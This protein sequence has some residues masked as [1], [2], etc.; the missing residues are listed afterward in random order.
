[1]GVDPGLA[2]VGWGVVDLDGARLVYRA[3]GCVGTK[4]TSPAADRLAAIRDALLEVMSAWAPAEA[5]ME[6][7]FFSRNVTS[8]LG[9]A[10][11][12]GVIRL[13]F[14][15]RSVPL[16]EYLPKAI[17]QSVAGSGGAGKVDVQN[18]VRMVLGLAE[19]PR[20]DHAADAL[21]VAICHC[22]SRSFRT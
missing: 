7:L 13:A 2:S 17:K 10:E 4:P 6:G 9:V 16:S 20:P 1:M 15:D 3:H 18:F 11:A 14:R 8:A 22:H 21:A 12:R 19:I 5:A